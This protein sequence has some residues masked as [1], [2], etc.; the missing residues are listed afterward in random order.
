M[1]LFNNF[2][3]SGRKKLHVTYFIVNYH[4]SDT[5]DTVSACDEMQKASYQFNPCEISF[6]VV[7]I[8]NMHSEFEQLNHNFR[9]LWLWQIGSL[10]QRP[11][12]SN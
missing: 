8:W 6:M 2:D 1:D 9:C 4:P 7:M 11:F 5:I 12:I 3:V 10:S